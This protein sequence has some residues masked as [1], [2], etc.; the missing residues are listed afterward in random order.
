MT[1]G[2][3]LKL[4]V[5]LSS[6][7]SNGD[8]DIQFQTSVLEVGKYDALRR[9][10]PSPIQLSVFIVFMYLEDLASRTGS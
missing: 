2:L 3:L 8:S 10:I 5:T 6:C 1:L 7:L 9:C 4:H